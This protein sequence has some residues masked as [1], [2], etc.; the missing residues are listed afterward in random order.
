MNI[1]VADYYADKGASPGFR[2]STLTSVAMAKKLYARDIAR[3]IGSKTRAV[4]REI[5]HLTMR[6]DCAKV[7]SGQIAKFQTT[8]RRRRHSCDPTEIPTVRSQSHE[9]PVPGEFLG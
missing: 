7:G 5:V 9:A 1:A 3:L 4:S 2:Q 6:T 8:A